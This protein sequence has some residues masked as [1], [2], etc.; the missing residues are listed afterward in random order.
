M[1]MPPFNLQMQQ[2]LLMQC[3]PPPHVT[4]ALN[5]TAAIK[6]PRLITVPNHGQNTAVASRQNKFIVKKNF[7]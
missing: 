7:F 2:N 1:D 5:I 3:L 4:V 6:Q